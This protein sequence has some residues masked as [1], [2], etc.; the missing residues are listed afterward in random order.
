MGKFGVNGY[1]KIWINF[2]K[3]FY[4]TAVQTTLF[5]IVGVD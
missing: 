5:D 3:T 1:G 2:G 4:R